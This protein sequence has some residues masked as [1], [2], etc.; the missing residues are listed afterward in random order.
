MHASDVC[1]HAHTNTHHLLAL[2]R[3]RQVSFSGLSR[4]E[5]FWGTSAWVWDN[6]D[7]LVLGSY[8]D[9]QKRL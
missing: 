5:L 7:K 6:A 8:Q 2:L 4:G 1:T 3:N 9:R